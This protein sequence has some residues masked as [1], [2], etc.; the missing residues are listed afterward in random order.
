M[1]TVTLEQHLN[2]IDFAAIVTNAVEKLDWSLSRAQ[3]AVKALREFYLLKSQYADLALSP[4][5]EVDEV[6]HLHIL[7]TRAYHKDCQVVFGEYLHHTPGI[8]KEENA[9]G[10]ENYQRLSQLYLKTEEVEPGVIKA[11]AQAGCGSIVSAKCSKG[12]EQ[13]SGFRSS[14]RCGGFT[15][16]RSRFGGRTDSSRCGRTLASQGGMD[17]S[18]PCAKAMDDGLGEK[19]GCR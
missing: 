13:G 4:S 17:V 12:H 10:W 5:S 11:A 7:N 2:T 19:A 3:T 18:A 8:G 6:W 16:K 15:M 1:N 14:A 9:E